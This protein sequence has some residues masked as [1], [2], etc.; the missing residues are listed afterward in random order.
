MKIT[1]F[2][3]TP[4]QI[5]YFL[6]K[7]LF[8]LYI[9]TYLIFVTNPLIFIH[10]TYLIFFSNPFF[11]SQNISESSWKRGHIYK[12]NLFKLFFVMCLSC[13]FNIS[14]NIMQKNAYWS[15]E[16]KRPN[17]VWTELVPN[18]FPFNNLAPKLRV[19]GW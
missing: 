12:V 14:F 16:S 11:Y 8:F 3:S 15:L 17:S 5:W 9:K 10:K 6:A 18:T 1:I 2:N 7:T 19:F 4:K 13:V